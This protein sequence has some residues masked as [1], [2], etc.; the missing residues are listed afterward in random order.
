[1]TIRSSL[2]FA[3]ALAGLALFFTLAPKAFQER[4]AKLR[5]D[6]PLMR[7]STS[8]LVKD[9]WNT[10]VSK[11]DVRP[12]PSLRYRYSLRMWQ[13]RYASTELDHILSADSVKLTFTDPAK[14]RDFVIVI[15]GNGRIA[16]VEARIRRGGRKNDPA[17]ASPASDT[18]AAKA[19]TLLAGPY[20]ASFHPEAKD[21]DEDEKPGSKPSTSSAREYR[22]RAGSSQ[23]SLDWDLQVR[24]ESDGLRY[25]RL[26]PQ[27]DDQARRELLLP[28]GTLGDTALVVIG[29]AYGTGATIAGILFVFAWM[30]RMVDKRAFYTA[31]GLMFAAGIVTHYLSSNGG[32][33]VPVVYALLCL[34]FGASIAVGQVSARETEWSAW[35]DM[36]LLL[37]RKFRARGIYQSLAWGA[38]WGGTLAAIPVVVRGSGFFPDVH[39]GVLGW[40]LQIL[41]RVPAISYLEGIYDTRILALFG[42][43]LPW[44]TQRIGVR[45]IS[46]AVFFPL[47]V[48]LGFYSTPF[49]SG[50]QGAL[51]C[52]VLTTAVYLGIYLRL[53]LLATLAA[54]LSSEC[55]LLSALFRN[56]LSPHLQQ[57]GTW[58]LLAMAAALTAVFIGMRF[59]VEMEP[60]DRMASRFLSQRER[61]KAEFS[62]AQQ[63]QQRL[64]PPQPPSLPGFAIATAC[65]PAREVGGDL[66]DFFRLADGRFGFCVADVSGKGLPAALYMT[67]TKGLLAAA[68]P[69]SPGLADLARRVNRHLHVA[70]KRK[71][72]VTAVMAAVDSDTRALEYLRAGHNPA[73]LLE[74]STGK[75]RYL[76]TPGVGLGLAGP[77]LFDRAAKTGQFPLASGDVLVFY[78]DGVTE[79][80]NEKLELYGEER[81]QQV[82]ERIGN[83]PAAHILE[84]IRKDLAAFTGTEPPHDD[85][86]LL[87]LQTI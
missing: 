40:L 3:A 7:Q 27:I 37:G 77:A 55:L 17:E 38:L 36:C 45:W 5:L 75:A 73:L 16:E 28:V 23:R 49:V 72:F 78:S 8:E 15:S 30:R 20:A 53:G 87:V 14:R 61:L 67:L 2:A 64:L 41:H 66:F 22:W 12:E 82:V 48:A 19:F 84:A 34:L 11:W 70:C 33:W 57:H 51:A 79:A 54:A 56:S 25:A 39:F 68:S 65:Q 44:I 10:D 1:M 46:I 59:S 42:I 47:S 71:M 21:M 80:M 52:S 31:S 4:T 69:E 43:L 86:T 63:A 29:V 50:H 18:I 9:L 83:K 35:R 24:V 60:V 81:F 26:T 32:F 85:I 74:K 62:M 6:H 13:E 58:L 76:T